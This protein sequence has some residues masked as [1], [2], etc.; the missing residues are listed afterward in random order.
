[1]NKKEAVL[2]ALSDESCS[3]KVFL[4]TTVLGG[5]LFDYFCIKFLREGKVSVVSYLQLCV[6]E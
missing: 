5:H 1:M 4:G 6:V 2:V 3:K